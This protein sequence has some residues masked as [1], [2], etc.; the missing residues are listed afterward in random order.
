[1][2]VAASTEARDPGSAHP[3]LSCVARQRSAGNVG[4]AS[5]NVYTAAEG[6][7]AIAANAVRDRIGGQNAASIAA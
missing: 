6:V 4:R 7:A 2:D 3:A 1:M 5:D